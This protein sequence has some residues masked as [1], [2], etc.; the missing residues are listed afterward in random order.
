MNPG[1][2][3]IGTLTGYVPLTT[4]PPSSTASASVAAASPTPA[5]EPAFDF[6]NVDAH[7]LHRRGEDFEEGRPNLEAY[8]EEE[9]DVSTVQLPASEEYSYQTRHGTTNTYVKTT[10]PI[11]NPGGFTIGTLNG[12]YVKPDPTSAPSHDELRS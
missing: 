11:V 6:Y 1:G 9:P 12:V 10:R 5:P 2:F 7:L 3:T 4:V 8:E